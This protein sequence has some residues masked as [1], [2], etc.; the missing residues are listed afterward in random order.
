MRLKKPDVIV[1]P[2]KLHCSKRES[3]GNPSGREC[4]GHPSLSKTYEGGTVGKARSVMMLTDLA[5]C[6]AILL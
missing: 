5:L 3:R 6:L 1:N 4:D 2:I